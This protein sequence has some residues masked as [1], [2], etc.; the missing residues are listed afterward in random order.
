MLQSISRDLPP[1][2][3]TMS[4]GALAF[5]LRNSIASCIALCTFLACAA[6]R[7]A[8]YMLP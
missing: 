8:P 2:T 1:R 6:P 4:A 3:R 5:L 7:A